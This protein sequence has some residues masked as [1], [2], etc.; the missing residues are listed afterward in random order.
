MPFSFRTRTAVR[1]IGPAQSSRRGWGLFGAVCLL[2]A[3]VFLVWLNFSF[4]RYAFT[5]FSWFET[6]GTVVSR[7]RTSSPTIRFSAHDGTNYS[8]SED[9]YLI[10]HRSICFVRYL[11]PGQV[12]PI[13]YDPSVPQR[14]FV[15]DWALIAGVL[16]WFFEAAIGVLMALVTLL[17]LGGKPIRFSIRAS[18]N[19]EER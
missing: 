7:S 17:L 12:V 19:F 4:A 9:Y 10:C 14:A 18:R 8:F 2:A 5:G 11:Q 6:D 3:C 1:T 15:H 13:V 16:N